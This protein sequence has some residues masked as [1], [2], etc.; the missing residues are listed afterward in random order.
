MHCTNPDLQ[1]AQ[2]PLPHSGGWETRRVYK[3][4]QFTQQWVS[5]A[6]STCPASRSGHR[7]E[8][9]RAVTLK[10]ALLW[11]S[12]WFSRAHLSQREPQLSKSARL[13]YTFLHFALIFHMWPNLHWSNYVRL[14]PNFWK[15]EKNKLNPLV[16][17]SDLSWHSLFLS[18]LQEYFIF[19]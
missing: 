3:E 7:W 18:N 2:P 6:G 1:K 11:V 16:K 14:K 5:A 15:S 10:Q 17:F 4:R 9:K 12:A 8:R 19:L 13:K